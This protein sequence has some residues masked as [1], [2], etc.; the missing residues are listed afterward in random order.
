ML[1]DRYGVATVE[2]CFDA[3]ITPPPGPTAREILAKVGRDLGLG[4]TTPS[5]A[6][7][8]DPACARRHPRPHGGG[9][10]R[11]AW[12]ST[13]G[14]SPQTRGPINHCGDYSDGVFLQ[15]G[16]RR[17]PVLADTPGGW[18][19]RRQR[20][21]RTLIGCASQ[22]GTLLT[23][24]L[25][26]AHER[27]DVRDPA[28]AGR[29]RRRGGEGGRQADAG[30]PER[31]T[32]PA[33][34][35]GTATAAHTSCA[36]SS[37]AARW[38]LLRPTAGTP[39]TWS[40][41]HGTCPRVHRGA[42]PLPRRVAVSLA[43][44]SGEQG[45]SAAASATKA[46]RMLGR[47][48]HVDR[49]PLDPGLLGR[50]RR[51]RD[52]SRSGH[53]RPRVARPSANRRLA[54][55]SRSRPA[56]HRIPHHRGGG[57]SDPSSG[58]PAGGPRRA[59]LEVSPRPRSPTTASCSPARSRATRYVVRR[60]GDADRARLAPAR[61]GVLPTA[62]AARLADGAPRRV[63]LLRRVRDEGPL[64]WEDCRVPPQVG[65]TE[66][67]GAAI[68]RDVGDAVPPARGR[69]CRLTRTGSGTGRHGGS[70]GRPPPATPARP[71]TYDA[72]W[73]DLRACLLPSHEP[74]RDRGPVPGPVGPH[75]GPQLGRPVRGSAGARD[76]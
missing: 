28:V 21:R 23:P 33:C 73:T 38:P 67:Q 7:S 40:P 35:A 36:E 17:S 25:S 50:P 74:T 48:L 16:W 57:W 58:H 6:A 52:K 5:T 45:S 46:R 18:P 76:R 37:V 64:V 9:R 75:Q 51:T 3:I 56:G 72:I 49:G 30:R 60:G 47:P 27:Q 39:S 31:S 13:S 10:R 43:V 12:C 70:S 29:A 14:A 22:A 26:G 1:F 44:D 68:G 2:S 65:A 66:R 8:G 4:R 71:R 53:H 54:D 55:A 15:I 11:S 41:T 32:T 61:T 19:A 63:D 62:V 69:R 42:L 24:G 34:T 59:L 20:G